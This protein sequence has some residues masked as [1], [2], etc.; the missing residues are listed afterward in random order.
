MV[1]F[2]FNPVLSEIQSHLQAMSPD[3]QAAVRMANPSLPSP[4]ATAAA[5]APSVIP[6]GMLLPHPDAGP[7]PANIS[8]GGP[9]PTLSM[10]TSQP[11]LVTGPKRGQEMMTS[12]EPV[13][14]G[15]TMGD[16]TE[17]GRLLSDGAGVEN[18]A[19]SVEGSRLGQAHPFLGKLL[20]GVAEGAGLVGDTLLHAA[21]PGIERT[22]PGTEGNYTRNLS[23]ADTALT[24]DTTNAQKEAQTASENATAGKTSAETPEVVPEAEARIGAEDATAG[25]ENA[26]AATIPQEAADKHALVQPTIGHL[27]AEATALQ[28]PK[29][30]PQE[31]TYADLIK[32][33]FTPEQALEKT[34]ERPPNVSVNTGEK[35]LWSVPQADGSQKVISLKAGDTIPKGAVSL[36]GQSAENSKAGNAD[37]PTVAALKFAND[38]LASGA[39]TGPSDEALQD[40]F[41][42]LAK[43]ST[44][45]RMNQAQ[46]SQLHEMASWMDSW[47]GRL[48]HLENGTWFAPEQRA[49]IVK[50]MN[51]LAASKG[52]ESGP[53]GGGM[54][55]ALDPRGVLHEAPAGTAL[56]AGWKAQ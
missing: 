14:P 19:H 37:A 24:Q 4:A 28:N 17:R 42:Q 40:Q 36:S 10:P 7:P 33:G 45:F 41:F 29:Q 49:N 2:N 47:K 44:G 54:I 26:T 48:Y 11:Q 43:P 21:A 20:G 13:S 38:Y 18:I 51:D 52:M 39:F 5:S 55:R 34:K 12:G 9:S 30:T 1:G 25:R 15:T 8:M 53:Q 32:Q 16:T 46:I 27:N 3:A 6:H 56:P 22:V 31:Q 23:R 35:N 50:T